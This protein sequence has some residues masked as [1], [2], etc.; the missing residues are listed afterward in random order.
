VSQLLCAHVFLAPNVSLGHLQ[1]VSSQVPDFLLI[2]CCRHIVNL[3]GRYCDIMREPAA[4]PL[5]S[6]RWGGLPELIVFAHMNR[7]AVVVHEGRN[8][9]GITPPGVVAQERVAEV[10]LAW[11]GGNHYNYLQP[12]PS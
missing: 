9:Y 3:A 4:S 2:F 6:L 5:D 7:V 10:H 8:L 11:R 12:A 1:P